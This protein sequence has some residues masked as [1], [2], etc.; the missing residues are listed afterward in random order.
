MT[1][2]KEHLIPN[3]AY[4]RETYAQG[5]SAPIPWLYVRRVLTGAS[6]WFRS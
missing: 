3:S 2:L 4:V 1:L 6:K 5:S